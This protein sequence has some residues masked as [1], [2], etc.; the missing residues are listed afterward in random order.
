MQDGVHG[1]EGGRDTL[2]TGP[3]I[4]E[5]CGAPGFLNIKAFDEI[6]SAPE[7]SR[8]AEGFVRPRGRV[9]STARRY[10]LRHYR[11]LIMSS[12]FESLNLGCLSLPSL[13]LA[14][15]FSPS[16]CGRKYFRDGSPR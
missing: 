12:S 1:A 2:K 7:P 10:S 6:I 11:D 3:I 13:S 14:L 16:D 5:T 15:L 8:T 9:G 4:I